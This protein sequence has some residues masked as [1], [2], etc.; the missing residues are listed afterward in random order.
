[1]RLALIGYGK[2]GKEIEILARERGHEIVCI[3]DSKNP[4]ESADFST[5]QVAIEFTKPALAI[6]HIEFCLEHGIP[7]V[8]GT[9]GWTAQLDS[10]HEKVN[11]NNG[12]LLHASNFSIGVNIF[13][14][15]NRKLAE[16]M[17]P[18]AK[19]Y[20]VSMEEIHHTQKLDA[21]SGTAISLAQDIIGGSDYEQWKCIENNDGVSVSI[22]PEFD[23]IAKRIPEV[24]GTHIVT[25]SSEID[26]LEIKHEAKNR[27]GFALGSILAA[28][29]LVGKNGVFTMKNVLNI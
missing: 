20:Q 21:P 18:H 5:V 10:I 17:N 14:E 16:L 28:E 12:S 13:F 4:I 15:I 6:H 9:T 3:V 7:I 29:W 1:M 19:E 24:P 2:M 26:T 25:Y 22:F 27:K 8:V 11:N 23:I